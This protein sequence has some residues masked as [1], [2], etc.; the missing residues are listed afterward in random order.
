MFK[1]YKILCCFILFY[2]LTNLSI[3]EPLPIGLFSASNLDGWEE[4]VFQNSTSYNLVSLD[5]RYVLS[6][7][8][9]DSASGLFKK[10]HIDIQKF[11][12]LNWSWRIENRLDIQDEKVKS[13]DDYA[14]RVYIVIDGG[15]LIWRTR[16]ISYVWANAAL[17][18][19]TWENAFAGKNAQMMALR[20]KEDKTLTWYSE[21]RNVHEDLMRLFNIDFQYV[22]A[23]AIMTDTDNSH[24]KAKAFYGDIYFTAK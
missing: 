22:D 14:A 13:G 20:S 21:K 5:N 18:G 10:V 12:Y 19:E 17:K 16:A 15:I 9:Q 1:K 23:V 24:E 6:A 3:A 8:S 4:K 2:S 11:P 7:E